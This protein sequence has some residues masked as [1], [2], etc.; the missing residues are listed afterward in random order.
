MES[1]SNQSSP[2]LLGVA[3]SQLELMLR[4]AVEKIKK[5]TKV[6]KIK[7]KVPESHSEAEYFDSFGGEKRSGTEINSEILTVLIGSSEEE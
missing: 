6:R 4:Q 1:N 2:V 3:D 5:K 7:I